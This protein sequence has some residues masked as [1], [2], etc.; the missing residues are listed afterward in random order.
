MYEQAAN[1]QAGYRDAATAIEQKPLDSLASAVQR[2]NSAQ[3]QISRFIDRF[4]GPQAPAEPPVGEKVAEMIQP[5]GVNL[6]RLFAAI[7]R[8]ETRV[9]ALNNIG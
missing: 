4:H 5:H 7:E 9:D 2:I 6:E 1:S 3:V 8:L